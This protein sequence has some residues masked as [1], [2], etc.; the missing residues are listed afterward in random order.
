M[1]SLDDLASDPLFQL[2]SLLWLAQP[3]PSGSDVTPLLWE[4]G[5]AVYA[6]AP[7]LTLPPDVRLKLQDAGLPHQGST[8]PDV[9]LRR[10][11]DRRHAMME[12]KGKSFGPKS[13]TAEQARTLL[14]ASGPR[15]AEILGLRPTDVG[16]S[17]AAYLVASAS[18]QQ[19]RETLRTL[20]KE[21]QS[22]GIESGETPVVAIESDSQAVYL[23]ADSDARD[24]FGLDERLAFLAVEA[25]ND[26]RPLYFIPYDPDC[27]QDPEQEAFCKR[28]LFERIQATVLGAAGRA[29]PPATV[30]FEAERLL[31]DATWGMYG[32]W[33]N[34][35]TRKHMRKLTRFLLGKLASA[36]CAEVQQAFLYIEG[37]RWLLNIA[38]GDAQARIC[39]VLSRFSCQTM[40]VSADQWELFD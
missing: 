20:R 2:N 15:A 8:R 16:R 26:P 18:A 21:L 10:E 14:V 27:Q 34:T 40:E 11:R 32:V 9:V 23:I 5:F 28:V 33:D 29:L 3:L 7:L 31:D 13:S 25:G 35:D 22:A 4:R 30:P 17:A 24:F 38:S 1:S 39:S 19:M 12:N 36:V 6:L 37:Q